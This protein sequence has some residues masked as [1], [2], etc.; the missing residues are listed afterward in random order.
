MAAVLGVGGLPRPCS[1]ALQFLPEVDFIFSSRVISS[2]FGLQASSVRQNSPWTPD[3]FP[4]L[5]LSIV[6]LLLSSE[7]DDQGYFGCTLS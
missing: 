6:K 1:L 2:L 3:V 7:Q 5:P 4:F